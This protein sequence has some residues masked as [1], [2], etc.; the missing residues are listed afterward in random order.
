M[1]QFLTT[2]AASDD[3]PPI[4]LT[5]EVIFNLGPVGITNSMLY[6]WISIIFITAVL[7][8][9]AR[10]M[11]VR[12]KGGFIQIIEVFA[13]FIRSTVEGAFENKQKAQKY[14]PFFLTIFLLILFVNWLG[15]MPFTRDA[16]ILGE[17]T[18]LLRPATA[19]FNATIAIAVITMVYVYVSS[20][21]ELGLGGF[22]GHF[23]I[24]SPKNPLY[25]IIGIL[26]MLSDL[27]RVFSLSL[28]LFLN[29]AIG[30]VLIAIFAFLGGYLAP[31]TAL[32]FF[33]ME[34]FILALQAYIFVVLGT[35]YLAIAVNH[36]E[37]AAEEDSLTEENITGRM[38]AETRPTG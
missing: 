25:F 21:R 24:G 18:Q 28:R 11:T 4:H 36:G 35:M 1:L 3:G 9:V 14:L 32:P 23:F 12:P 8:I 6:G 38:Q 15:L 19:S 29:V 20:V 7:I 2:F 33:L 34:L 5:Q 27:V 31:L 17:E 26:E 10:K 30:E 16:I 13:E 37:H 22:F